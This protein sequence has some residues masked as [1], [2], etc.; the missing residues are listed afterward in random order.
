LEEKDSLEIRLPPKGKACQK[1]F[2]PKR[3]G[4]FEFEVQP[5][6]K[7]PEGEEREASVFQAKE[8]KDLGNRS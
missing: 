6:I 3:G 1:I 5:G 7:K 2:N 4:I 8:R